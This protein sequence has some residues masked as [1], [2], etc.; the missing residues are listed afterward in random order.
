MIDMT[1]WHF[2]IGGGHPALVAHGLAQPPIA[3]H[4]PT[5]TDLL[6][7]IGSGNQQLAAQIEDRL[8]ADV[9][10]VRWKNLYTR[11]SI[12]P[13]FKSYRGKRYDIYKAAA[14]ARAI[15]HATPKQL[16]LANGLSS[17]IAASKVIVNRGQLV[18]HGRSDQSPSGGPVY[19]GFLSTTL[20]PFVAQLSAI[21]RQ[22]QLGGRQTVYLFTVQRD[23]PAM[24]GH[25]GA[26]SEW[27]LLFDAGLPVRQTAI[28]S[29]GSF[30]V[31][32]AT[33]G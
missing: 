5:L 25:V 20:S 29:A 14:L 6:C 26:S 9:K 30:D 22:H 21:R 16:I 31:V 1:N 24:W 8:K 27:E 18:L 32:E 33:L 11:L 23:M 28:H 17:E 4:F 15:G 3:L 19:N 10:S 12:A 7:Y 2:S 13:H